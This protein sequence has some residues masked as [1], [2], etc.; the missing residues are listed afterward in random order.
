MRV[1]LSGAESLDANSVKEMNR[2]WR[3]Y[4]RRAR[5]KAVRTESREDINEF[6]SMLSSERRLPE[7]LD[8]IAWKSAHEFWPIFLKN[9]ATC[10][11]V[12][13]YNLLLPELFRHAGPATSFLD[14]CTRAFFDSLADE[15]TVYRGCHRGRVS[16]I[17]WTTDRKVASEFASGHRG[18]RV[19][20]PALAT[21]LVRKENIFAV[22]CGRNEREILCRPHSVEVQ[23]V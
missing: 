17:S 2:L 14:E 4:V 1:E 7:M 23:G 21:G 8:L 19:I 22:F 15:I 16:G 20:D 5:A 9:W 6:L 11:D 12:W 13:N 3:E 10:D 18:I